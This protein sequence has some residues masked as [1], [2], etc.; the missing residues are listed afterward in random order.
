ML[1]LTAAKYQRPYAVVT[2]IEEWW[3]VKGKF[4]VAKEMTTRGM[5]RNKWII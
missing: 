2:F 1:P 3:C 4:Y 5:E